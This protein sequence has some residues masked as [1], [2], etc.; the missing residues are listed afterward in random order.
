LLVDQYYPPVQVSR[1]HLIV[2]LL[3]LVAALI[4]AAAAVL[5]AL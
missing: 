3:V 5:L 2:E 1:L 4:L